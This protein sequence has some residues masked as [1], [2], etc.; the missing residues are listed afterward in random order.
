MFTKS[1]SSKLMSG[2]SKCIFTLNN[3]FHSKNKSPYFPISCKG[4]QGPVWKSKIGDA[5]RVTQDR[6]D[7]K[8]FYAMNP[9]FDKWNKGEF[10]FN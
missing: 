2:D 5:L 3:S 4:K 8:N 6:L 1:Q 10:G 9:G 7:S